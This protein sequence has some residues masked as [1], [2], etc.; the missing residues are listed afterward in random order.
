MRIVINIEVNML[1]RILNVHVY[2][3]YDRRPISFTLKNFRA[4]DGN[5]THNLLI[6]AV[7]PSNN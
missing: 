5:R 7:R 4:P 1:T 6:T 2:V 3:N